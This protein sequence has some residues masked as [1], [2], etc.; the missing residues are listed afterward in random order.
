MGWIEHGER[1]EAPKRILWLSGPAGSGKTAIAGTIADECYKNGMLAASFFFS[2]FAR[3]RSR[4]WKKPLIATLLYSLLQHESIAGYKEEVLAVIERDPMVFE[5]HLDQQLDKLILEPLRK[6]LGCSDS[7]TWPKVILV[8]GLDE[9]QGHS[10]PDI[11][12]ETDDPAAGSNAQKEILA[13]LSRACTEP[14]FPFYI[15]VASR[16]EP[17]IRHFFSTSPCPTLKVFLDNKY[18]PGADIR[19][20]LEAMFNDIRRRSNLP[21]TWVSNEVIDLLVKE[22]SGQFIYAATVIRFVDNPSAG[23]PQEQLNQLL[24]W[25]R[26]D[27]LQPFAPLDLLYARILR[28][29]P[30][31]ILA[32]KWLRSLKYHGARITSHA[33]L[34]MYF[35]SVL[36]SYPGQTEYIL[37]NLASLVGLVDGHGEPR[38]HFYHKSLIDFLEDPHRS[39]DLYADV[40]SVNRF[41]ADRYYRVLQGV[42]LLHGFAKLASYTETNAAR[43]PEPSTANPSTA[44]PSQDFVGA[45]SVFLCH[46]IDPH[47]RYTLGD[48]EWWLANLQEHQLNSIPAMF[49]VIHRKVGG[50][51]SF[52]SLNARC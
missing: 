20:F 6:A 34:H 28:H 24:E 25:R 29:S 21:L 4:R 41:I 5:R 38:F 12:P 43:G 44:P 18:N 1:D 17:V 40:R 19:L 23:P 47:H 49:A 33:N 7:R 15:I 14:A 11:G 37:G 10:E 48:V 42:Y 27:H 9:C 16:P 39:S 50:H 35:R 13:A 36:E 30:D 3:S 45:F 22:A 51:S 46:F 32:V 8:D 31:P 26:L 52:L 2:A